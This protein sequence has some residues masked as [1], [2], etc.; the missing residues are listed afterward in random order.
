[1]GQFCENFLE[2]SICMNNQKSFLW[3]YGIRIGW[4]SFTS[5]VAFVTVISVVLDNCVLDDTNKNRVYT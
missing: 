4:V 2:Q 5:M 1:M 3:F